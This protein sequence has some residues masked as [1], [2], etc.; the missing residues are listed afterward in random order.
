MQH[1]I[2]QLACQHCDLLVRLPDNAKGKLA[3]P[4]C[5][6]T[7]TRIGNNRQTLL[8]LSITSLIL[9]FIANAF[10][11]LSLSAQG[12]YQEITLLQSVVAL[13]QQ[14]YVI[15]ALMILVFILL[16]PLLFLLGII[17][18]L[19]GLSG[20]S[21][22]ASA[23]VMRYLF[24]LQHWSMVE[25]FLVGVLISLIKIASMANIIPGISFWAFILFTIAVSYVLANIDHLQLWRWWQRA[26][27]D[28]QC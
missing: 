17:Y 26:N 22:T 14:N 28:E 9:L 12:Q 2:Q 6:H 25:V 4:R 23:L 3:C 16:A 13:W 10:P 20:R 21:L 18:L 1:S 27:P 24:N 11:F 5:G 15:L 8:A 19:T 7:I